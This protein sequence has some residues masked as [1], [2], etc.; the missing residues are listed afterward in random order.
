MKTI[1]PMLFAISLTLICFLW[2]SGQDTSI[3]DYQD[4]ATKAGL[5]Q[6]SG[7]VRSYEG[8]AIGKALVLIP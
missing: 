8:E 5:F 2:L 7:V 6:I 4:L 1:K 3:S